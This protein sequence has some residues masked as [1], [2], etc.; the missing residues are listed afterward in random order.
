VGGGRSENEEKASHQGEHFK[1]A[2]NQQGGRAW[3]ALKILNEIFWGAKN[4]GYDFL[5]GCL[6]RTGG[7][8][9]KWAGKRKE[10]P[11]RKLG[12]KI[13]ETWSASGKNCLKRG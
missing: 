2:K 1:L 12:N 5:P 9:K 8:K 4:K 7:K 3:D 6:G 10:M 11:T 13:R